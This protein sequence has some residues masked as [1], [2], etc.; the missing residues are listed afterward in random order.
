[1]KLLHSIEE[2]FCSA[3]VFLT[4][5][6]VKAGN[7]WMDR[8][9]KRRQPIQE[10]TNSPIR[11]LTVADIHPQGYVQVR[12]MDA[13][14]NWQQLHNYPVRLLP[15]YIHVVDNKTGERVR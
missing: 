1:M 15:P 10:I 2:F 13:N 4:T 12:A 11:E 3:F 7:S 14:G 8:I 9:L 5:P 6:I